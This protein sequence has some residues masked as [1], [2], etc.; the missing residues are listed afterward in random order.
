[1]IIKNKWLIYIIGALF[2]ISGCTQ[3]NS[4]TVSTPT[5]DGNRTEIQTRPVVTPTQSQATIG[6]NET[7]LDGMQ[8][9]FLHPW[10]GAIES[11]LAL[12][13]DQ[14]NQTNDWGIHVIMN[15]P[16]SAGMAAQMMWELIE[17]GK[18]PNVVAAPISLLLAVDEKEKVVADLELYISSL[19]YGMTPA[20][21]EDYSPIFWD[22]DNVDGKQYAIPAQRTATVMIYNSSWAN[23]LGYDHAPVTPDEFQQQVCAA[24]AVQRKDS[25]FTND[26]I[27]G[28][29]INT[30]STVLL[31][32]LEAF[33][34]DI[35]DN[36]DLRFSS[37]ESED[38]FSFL[39]G[40][41]RKSCAW[42]G[43]LPQPYEYFARRQTLIYSGQLQDIQMQAN[44]M[45]RTGSKDEWQ[46]ISFPGLETRPVITSGFSYA[47]LQSDPSKDLAAWLFIR[48]LSEPAQ[49]ARMLKVSG[50][51]PLGQQVMTQ[52]VE[53]GQANPQWKQAVENLNDLVIQPK[54]ADWVIIN[55]VLED[56]GWQLFNSETKIDQIPAL[57]AQMDDLT[58]ELSERFP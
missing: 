32:W 50:T 56:S 11:E 28:W 8:I 21:R 15:S 35:Y 25:D 1:M 12:M 55:P 53:Y 14:F 24:N 33:N 54:T 51:L 18:T 57:I 40:L 41:A 20:L 17:E 26:G 13:V 43:K 39:F 23:E 47:I 16:G 38:A 52:M 58:K 5:S 29:I 48:W 22:E 46:A 45:Q 36:Q 3:K 4:I 10:S 49:Q 37:P 44:F 31:N 7:K 34:A 6:A 2:I 19:K 9:H 30:S 42:V 27:G